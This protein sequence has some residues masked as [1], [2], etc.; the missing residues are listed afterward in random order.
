MTNERRNE[1]GYLILKNKMTKEGIRVSDNTS[2]EIG[3][4]ARDINVPIKEVK[5]FYREV[6]KEIIEKAYQ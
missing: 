1:I 2:L 5:E 6:T 3:V 4:I